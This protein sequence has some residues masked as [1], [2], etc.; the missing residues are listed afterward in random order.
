ME[1]R[2]R[3]RAAIQSVVKSIRVWFRRSGMTRALVARVEMQDGF[4]RVF[5]I[6]IDGKRNSEPYS[7]SYDQLLTPAQVDDNEFEQA[8]EGMLSAEDHDGVEAA[9]SMI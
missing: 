2:T 1:L 7:V 8:A 9:L 3:I 6:R 5:G 4:V